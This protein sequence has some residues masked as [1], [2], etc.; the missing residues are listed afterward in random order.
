MSANRS[1]S[2]SLS[3][4]LA[5]A[6]A[7]LATLGAAGPA[8]ATVRTTI[9]A[10]TNLMTVTS[11]ADD[12][13]TITCENGLAIVSGDDPFV[14]CDG[15]ER[16]RV[17]GGPGDNAI[18]VSG[19]DPGEFTVLRGT[20]L[21]GGG[22]DDT[23]TGTTLAE[24]LQGD[25]GNDT[26]EGAG[27]GDV[28]LGGDGFDVASWNDGDGN[29]RVDGQGDSD[30]AVVRGSATAGDSISVLANGAGARLARTNL[31]PVRLDVASAGVSVHA[32]GGDDVVAA[33][34]A[35]ATSVIL[36][37]EDGNDSL[38][39]GAGEDTLQGG[40]GADRL[41]GRGAQDF[42]SGGDGDDVMDWN[43]GDGPDD[44]EGGAG[45]DTME[46]EGARDRGDL[47]ILDPV[48]CPNAPACP[49]RFRVPAGLDLSTTER[50][51]ISGRGGDDQLIGSKGMPNTTKFVFKGQRGNDT[52]EGTDQADLLDGGPGADVIG[53]VDAFGDDVE[54][55]GGSD[56]AR[57]DALDRPRG[58]EQLEGSDERVRVGRRTAT[59][60]GGVVT[61]NLR[62]AATPRC[63]GTVRLTHRGAR[64][65]SAR[66]QATSRQAKAVRVGL[67]R[68][69]RRL[70][71]AAV[72]DPS[73]VARIWARDRAG[74][75]WLTT[76]RVRPR[77]QP[78]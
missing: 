32:G 65:G 9:Q 41:I 51:L 7:L 6:V 3:G 20:E 15:V 69:G 71:R 57:V 27:G 22:G 12:E 78:A 68:R 33:A 52:L 73:M 76:V 70:L 34:P 49:V 75:G 47:F 10:G 61:L 64:L 2:R 14:G 30:I 37:G 54:C 31:T 4:A 40:A 11:D 46:V 36:R 23:I 62:C 8:G 48:N 17:V 74:N 56:R 13:I 25:Q 1:K 28:V 29:D 77:A 58:C 39:G 24:T 18:D 19:V 63:R 16:L 5:I 72:R 60:A 26:L 21:S 42:F 67:N 55:G 59:A 50:V 35:L 38:S 44:V 66:F 45:V 43:D 53:S